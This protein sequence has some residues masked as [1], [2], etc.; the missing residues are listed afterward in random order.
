MLDFKKILDNSEKEYRGNYQVNFDFSMKINGDDNIFALGDNN[1]FGRFLLDHQV[2]KEKVQLF[3]VDPPFFSKA[4]YAAS[5]S[6]DGKS[7]KFAAYDDRWDSNME[8]Y[9]TVLCTQ[10]RLM[11][12]LLKKEGCFFIHLDWHVVHYVKVLLDEIF[13]QE[14]FRNEIIWQY[15]SGGASKKTFSRKHDTILFYSKSDE[16]VFNVCKEKSYNRGLKP[17]R[18]KGVDEFEDNV[19]WYTLVNQKDVWSID[20]V[21]RTSSERTGYATQKPEELVKRIVLAGSNEGD[22]CADFFSGSG[23]LAAVAAKNNRKF[24]CC[25]S[26][27]MAFSSLVSRVDFKRDQLKVI[28]NKEV[29]NRLTVKGFELSVTSANGIA[30]LTINKYVPSSWGENI[31]EKVKVAL[32]NQ[33]LEKPWELISYLGIDIFTVDDM[34]V[35]TYSYCKSKKEISGELVFDLKDSTNFRLLIVDILGNIFEDN[36][37]VKNGKFEE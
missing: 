1:S 26:G 18:F 12:D 24:I 35:P 28:S 19:G 9:L 10:V 3:Y 7:V 29:I 11:K 33:G 23:T 15:K 31:D 21:G 4:N 27:S 16:Y 17:Y 8:E 37:G 13:G 14:N 20:M 36:I 5:F 2:Y 32:N 25:D 34:F 30:T 22:I 6:V